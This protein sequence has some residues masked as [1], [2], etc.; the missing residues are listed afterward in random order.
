MTYL[1]YI[2]FTAELPNHSHCASGTNGF[3]L[4]LVHDIKTLETVKKELL[5]VV[6]KINDE[7]KELDSD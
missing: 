4:E 2:D 5:L 6:E 7:I 3:K 1:P